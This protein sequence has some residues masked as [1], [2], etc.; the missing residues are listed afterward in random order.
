[1]LPHE[2]MDAGACTR[3]THVRVRGAPVNTHTHVRLH[4]YVHFLL[5]RRSHAWA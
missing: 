2:I 4:T 1:V 5:D 3:S